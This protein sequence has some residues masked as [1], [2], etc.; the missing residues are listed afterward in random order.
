MGLFC[1]LL[2]MVN[3]E[4]L[5]LVV[6]TLSVIAGYEYLVLKSYRDVRDIASMIKEV[7]DS[8]IIDRSLDF[9]LVKV[10]GTV[11]SLDLLEDPDIK[12]VSSNKWLKLE[13]YM[14]HVYES[15]KEEKDEDGNVKRLYYV[16]NWGKWE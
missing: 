1:E 9:E 12:I 11:Q 13:R 14:S 10:S 15:V 5:V 3:G 8:K 4:N 6:L 7:P 16:N 2:G